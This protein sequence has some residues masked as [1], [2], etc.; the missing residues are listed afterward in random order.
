VHHSGTLLSAFRSAARLHRAALVCG[1]LLLAGA[2]DASAQAQAGWRYWSPADG[3]QESHSRKIGALP[4]GGV[5]IRHG[6]VKSVDFLDGYV[7]EAVTEPRAGNT[8]ETLM[9]SV[10][11]AVAGDAWAISEGVLKQL[12]GT[13]WVVRATPKRGDE[14]RGAIPLAGGRVLVLFATRVAAFDAT[15]STWTTLVEADA[16]GLGRFGT[17]VRGFAGELWIAAGRGVGRLDGTALT[18]WTPFPAADLEDFSS[19]LP[20]NG[21]ELFAAAVDAR[22]RHKVALRVVDGRYQRVFESPKALRA[23]RGPHG[24]VWVLEGTRTWRLSGGQREAVARHGPLSG[25]VYDVVTEPGGVF[26]IASTTGVGRYAPQLWRTPDAIK[27][28]DQPVHAAVEDAG[29]RLWFAATESLVELD[30]T[31]WRV[32]PLPPDTQTVTNQTSSLAVLPD[33]RLAMTA[34]APSGHVVLTFD[35]RSRTFGRLSHPDGRRLTQ[36]WRGRADRVL[37]R[38]AEPCGLEVWD[39]TGTHVV[40]VLS[41]PKTC[42]R[43]REVHDA[44]D[45]S[46]WFGTTAFGGGVLRPDR[47][48]LERFGPDDGYPELAVYGLFA[49]ATDRVLAGGRD[50]LAERAHGR[51][52]VRHRALD[53]VRS[54]MQ[55]RDGTIWIASGSGVHQL[56][57]GVWLTNGEAD[58]LPADAAFKVLE[59]SKGRIW[60]GTG[61]GLGLYDPTADRDAPRA[62]LAKSNAAEAP[63]DGDINIAFTGVDRWKYTLPDRLLFSYRLDGGPWSEFHSGTTAPLRRL[64]RGRHRFEVR[65]MDRNGNLGPVEAFAFGVPF[66]WYQQ[67]GFLGIAATSLIVIGCLIGFARVQYRQ[68]ADAKLAAETANRCKSEF[69]AHMSHEIRTPMN[70]IM[71]MTQLA[72]DSTDPGEQ[73]GYLETVQ[74]ASV[75]LLALL[76]DILDLSKV[77]AGKLEL[78]EDSFDVHQCVRDALATLHLR[79]SEKGLG[80]RAAIAA[81]V[82]RYVVGDELRVRQIVMNLLGNAIKFTDTGEV[83]VRV[84]VVP[85]ASAGVEL[86]IT[87]TDTGIG[88][89]ADKQRVIFAPFEQADRSTTRKYGGTGLGLA[90]SSRL[91]GL[92]HGAITIESPWLDDE[93]GARVPGTAFHFTARVRVGSAPARPAER[94]TTG[95]RPLQV[96][97]AEDN[98]VNQLLATRLLQRLGHTVTTASNGREA[99][100]RLDELTPDVILMDVQMPE[101]DGFEATAAIRAREAGSDRRTPIIALTAHALQGYREECVRAGMDDYLTKP[102]ALGDLARALAVVS[103]ADDDVR[104]SA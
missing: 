81:D 25:I 55:A 102:I 46:V 64:A 41:A 17:M 33:G 21:G 86:R 29:G 23:W 95:T 93:T 84:R 79:A 58:G 76:D 53:A 73:H 56:R 71:G 67:P 38:T 99:V 69:L 47:A 63:P 12:R 26:W 101:M 34:A 50:A 31:T 68:L 66:P 15:R 103:A 60:A 82:P 35:P 18:R 3:I 77:E 8:P 16:A 91:V 43:L 51:W 13:T 61:R 22:T 80:L 104:R 98:P 88:V 32:H 57:Q 89:A 90:I 30:G 94:P 100:Q 49:P 5:T 97:V 6:L 11:A 2:S 36:V 45:G 75:S 59:D 72:K 74:T 96:L 4:G 44:A 70:A 14:M 78:A 1:A 83:T 62:I 52:T 40:P 37:M 48:A 19:P 20:G 92:M 54:L 87:I 39:R 7:V 65:A 85:S 24:S 28:L 42:D 27:G 10:D 9:A